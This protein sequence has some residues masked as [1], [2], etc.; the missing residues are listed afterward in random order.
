[1]SKVLALFFI[2]LGVTSAQNMSY[3]HLKNHTLTPESGSIN[4]NLSYL[5][6]NNTVDVLNMKEKELGNSILANIG[7][8]GDMSGYEISGGYGLRDD[9]YLSYA[10]TSQKIDYVGG[11]LDNK[12]DELF[13]RYN[14]LQNKYALFNS[15]VSVDIGVIKNR[16]DDLVM[17]DLGLVNK[18]LGKLNRDVNISAFDYN[19]ENIYIFVSPE[20]D[21]PVSKPHF[22]ITQMSD[23]GR[24]IKL[25]AGFYKND[26]TVDFYGGYRKNSI[27]TFLDSS[28]LYESVASDPTFA[29]QIANIKSKQNLNRDESVVFG[30][31]AYSATIKKIFFEFN[32]EFAKISRDIINENNTNHTIDL[33]VGYAFTHGWYVFAGGKMMSNQ[34]NS[35]LPYLYN[36]YSASQFDKKYGWSKMG[37]GFRF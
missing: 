20:G 4:L 1:M 24:Y 12:K 9:L 31:V 23:D 8:I 30:G 5:L 29:T 37:V 11:E 33:Y 27:K 32:Y 3:A 21:F 19:G 22:D 15:G 28:L 10:K 17:S 25:L 2:F 14:I 6:L 26:S 34:F 16:A 35:E 18:F 7:A 13:L 36:E